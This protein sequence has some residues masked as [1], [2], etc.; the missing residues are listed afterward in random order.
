LER[1]RG[2]GEMAFMTRKRADV[3]L[4]F[5][6]EIGRPREKLLRVARLP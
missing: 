1:L 6:R 3:L 5:Q 4:G 2:N